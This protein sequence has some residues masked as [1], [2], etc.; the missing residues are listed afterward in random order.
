MYW[1]EIWNKISFAEYLVLEYRDTYLIHDPFEVIDSKAVS[2][3]DIVPVGGVF[4]ISKTIRNLGLGNG[5]PDRA[6]SIGSRPAGDDPR[7]KASTATRTH[8]EGYIC[9]TLQ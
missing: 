3:V 7:C 1:V 6:D 8:W 2:R 4:R 9:Q 5:D